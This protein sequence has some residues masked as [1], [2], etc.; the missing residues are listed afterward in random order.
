MKNT[1]KSC[2]YLSQIYTPI[3]ARTTSLKTLQVVDLIYA[4]AGESVNKISCD[5]SSL[6]CSTVTVMFYSHD[7]CP[8]LTAFE[9]NRK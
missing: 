9:A 3:N 8:L 7:I 1:T 4:L 2:K 6:L 5:A